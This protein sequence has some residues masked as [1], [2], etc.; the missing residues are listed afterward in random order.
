MSRSSRALI[1]AVVILALCLS[2]AAIA[3]KMKSARAAT[4]G[5]GPGTGSATAS[6][7]LDEAW[8]YTGNFRETTPMK[9]TGTIRLSASGG[10]NDSQARA[11][12]NSQ[13]T[14]E[15]SNY[16]VSV[17]CPFPISGQVFP[18]HGP[19]QFSRPVLGP[20]DLGT[21]D[22]PETKAHVAVFGRARIA[23]D[24]D[25]IADNQPAI[26]LLNEAIHDSEQVLMSTADS[27]SNELSLIIPG[28][29]NGQT[30]VKGFPNGYFYIFWPNTTHTL[31]GNTSARPMTRPIPSRS[32]RGPATPII[33]TETPRGT[34][35]ISLTNNGIRK[36][37][38]E[39]PT[40]LYDLRITNSSSGRR[41]LVLSGIDLC[42]TPYTR[43]SQLLRP[44]QTQVIRWYF[45]PG[46]VQLRDFRGGV[47]TSTSWTNVRYAGH[48][49]SINFTE[50]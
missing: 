39:S 49:S 45:A 1:A 8:I 30:F 14:W 35:N 2:V 16:R 32:G 42:C 38:G 34:I 24:G 4:V 17:T 27:S 28:P 36:I 46:K 40:G 21:L 20:R 43:F 37:V 3:A 29:M 31:R 26:V 41:G 44:G 25:I 5:A 6:S 22:L 33:G 7:T 15:G 47:R 12:V 11:V 13:F 9:T 50:L 48:S 23:R 18:G 10:A 19:V